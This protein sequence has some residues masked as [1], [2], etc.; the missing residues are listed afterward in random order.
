MH[1]TPM[2]ML[3]PTPCFLFIFKIELFLLSL[4]KQMGEGWPALHLL[5][6]SF[7]NL[8]S[9]LHCTQ[10]APWWLT[11][12]DTWVDSPSPTGIFSHLLECDIL[13]FK[14]THNPQNTVSKTNVLTKWG[15][16]QPCVESASTW[17]WQSIYLGVMLFLTNIWKHDPKPTEVDEKL[18]SNFNKVCITF[19]MATAICRD[20][21]YCLNKHFIYTLCQKQI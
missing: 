11:Q 1:C 20:N 14:Q 10:T 8:K 2:G 16:Q 17:H 3:T 15:F 5:L 19:W 7:L 13:M 6:V 9:W 12:A 18:S 21:L 4:L